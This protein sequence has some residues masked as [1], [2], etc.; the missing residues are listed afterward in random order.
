M[1]CPECDGDGIL[2]L[3]SRRRKGAGWYTHFRTENCFLCRG[4]GKISFIIFYNSYR[5]SFYDQPSPRQYYMKR[6]KKI[7]ISLFPFAYLR[8][9]IDE[10]FSRRMP[11]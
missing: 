4:K 11:L 8:S 3:R 2:R 9:R 10:F 6:I 7:M 5:L 1:K